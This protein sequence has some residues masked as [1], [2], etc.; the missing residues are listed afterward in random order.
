MNSSYS[1]LNTTLKQNVRAF[2]AGKRDFSIEELN[3]IKIYLLRY[4]ETLSQTEFFQGT[5]KEY[6]VISC[7]TESTFYD[8]L[9]EYMCNK[10]SAGICIIVVLSEK[11]V[12]LLRNNKICSIDLC[13]LAKLLCDGDCENLSVDIAAGKI[14]EKFLKFTKTLQACTTPKI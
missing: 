5:L 12:L 6:K 9:F 13:T 4:K 3:N 2:R 8:E 11:K 1:H 14:T 7:F 10:L